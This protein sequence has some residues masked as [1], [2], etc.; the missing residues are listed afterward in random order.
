VLTVSWVVAVTDLPQPVTLAQAHEVL[1]R[2][3][4][5]HEAEPLLW[6]EFHRHSAE[7]Y[8]EVAKVDQAHRNEAGYW[9]GV[10]IRRA[11]EIED[12]VTRR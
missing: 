2:L 7:I 3:R 4:P 10:E 8:A 1:M 12:G 5:R 9:A 11:R 6:V